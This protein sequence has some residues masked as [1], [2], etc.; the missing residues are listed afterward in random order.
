ML[1][2]QKMLVYSIVIISDEYENR[3]EF[4]HVK[5]IPK[6]TVLYSNQAP[7]IYF[8]RSLT[9]ANTLIYD[10]KERPNYLPPV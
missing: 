8:D 2:R 4:C 7:Y 1:V 3:F 6:M 5:K 10:A 9:F